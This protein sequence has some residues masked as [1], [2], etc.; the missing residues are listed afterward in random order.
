MYRIKNHTLEVL[1][2]HPGGPFFKSKDAG[3]WSIPKGEI[4][5]TEELLDTAVREFFEETGLHSNGPYV[6]LGSIV[7]KGGKTV[8]AWAFEG[9]EEPFDVNKSNTFEME[10]PLHSGKKM[11]FLEIDKVEFFTADAA[12][13]KI[14]EAQIELI[15]RLE[16]YLHLR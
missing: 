14:K 15:D 13:K 16:D 12:R 10:W 5:G 11:M 3:Y 1:L 8:H 2:A 7:Q 6:S 9:Q 4:D